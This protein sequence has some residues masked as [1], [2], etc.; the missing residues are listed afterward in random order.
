MIFWLPFCSFST[1]LHVSGVAVQI[2][3]L[4]DMHSL[5]SLAEGVSDLFWELLAKKSL[6][7]TQAVCVYHR[8][9]ACFG[10]LNQFSM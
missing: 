1:L 3:A 5:E 4:G 9:E 2:A 8:Q 7:K 10:Q 6:L